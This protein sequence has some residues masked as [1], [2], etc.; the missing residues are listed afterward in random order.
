MKKTILTSGL[1]L[2]FSG[3]AFAESQEAET[4][5]PSDLTRVYTQAAVFLDSNADVRASGMWTGAWNDN[6]QF[7]GFAEGTFGNDKA[8]IEGKH[9]VGT[10]YQ[11][12]RA[13]YFQVHA[14]NNSLM[15]RIGFS[16]DL[17]HQNGEAG[18]LKGSGLKDTTLFSAG[19]IG[20]INPAYTFGAKVFPNVAY[21]TGQVFGE[22]ADGY[23]FNLFLTKEFGGSGSFIQFSPEYFKVEGDV[24]EMESSKLNFFISAP[25]RPDR[26][27]WLMTRFEYGSAD[28]VLPDGT[29]I[30]N[31]PELRVE[32]GMKWFF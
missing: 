19:A 31:D 6:I 25:T 27:Q 8:K 18:A 23:M 10:D 15:P 14:L 3:A 9:K 22:S 17:I 21:T 13:Q 29:A 20:L 26:S 5:N 32:I 2:A 12:G 28:V 30:D 4:I 11:K 7:A 16:T 24:V 1:L